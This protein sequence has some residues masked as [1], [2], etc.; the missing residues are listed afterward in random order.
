ML[1]EKEIKPTSANS[2]KKEGKGGKE[3]L[4][5]KSNPRSIITPLILDSMDNRTPMRDL[6]A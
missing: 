6:E 5:S 2:G 1:I 3:A 4:E